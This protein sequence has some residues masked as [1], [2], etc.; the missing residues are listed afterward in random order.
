MRLRKLT[1]GFDLNDALRRHLERIKGGV[2]AP[3][4]AWRRLPDDPR[5]SRITHR[6]DLLTYDP[7]EIAIGEESPASVLLS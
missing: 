7:F 4:Q 5:V 6:L 3:R 2:K 1:Q